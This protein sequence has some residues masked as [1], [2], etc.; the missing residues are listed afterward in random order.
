MLSITCSSRPPN[1]GFIHTF[2]KFVCIPIGVEIWLLL[3]ST[4]VDGL[5]FHWFVVILSARRL[6]AV[7]DGLFCFLRRKWVR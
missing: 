1:D 6:E 4:L 5:A 7:I 3:N 2:R